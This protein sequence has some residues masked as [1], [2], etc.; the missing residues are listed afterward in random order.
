MYIELNYSPRV[1]DGRCG[2]FIRGPWFHQ[3]A[4]HRLTVQLAVVVSIDGFFGILQGA[5]D[6][7]GHSGAHE[8][9]FKQIAN[10][11]KQFLQMWI[12]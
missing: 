11:F 9:R 3:Q 8:A 1:A 12:Y 10:I 2:W 4:L 6:D 7:F 5:V